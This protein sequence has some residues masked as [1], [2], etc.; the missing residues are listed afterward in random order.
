MRFH[1]HKYNEIILLVRIISIVFIINEICLSGDFT[2]SRV[3]IFAVVLNFYIFALP[4]FGDLKIEKPNRMY[5]I[6]NIAGQQFKVEKDQKLFVHRLEEKEGENVSF[7]EVLLIDNDKSVVVGE[8]T[9]KGAM[10]SGKVI[11]HPRGDKIKVFKK[12]RRKGYKVRT[13]HRQYL[14][15]IQIEDIIEKGAVK[16]AKAK[17]TAKEPASTKASPAAK[18]PA[19]EASKTGAAKTAPAKE[20]KAAGTSAAPKTA[21]KKPAA[22]KPAAKSATDK[23][24]AKK[25]PVKKPAAAKATTAKPAAKKPAAKKPAAKKPD[26]GKETKE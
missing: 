7:D 11:S 26:A 8:P 24:A 10:I 20:E 17:T 23:P 6:V 1:S 2:K 22:K 3:K 9:I 12:K 5:A 16:E 21:A 25:P 15:E 14:T 4:S 13:G 18:K 19:A